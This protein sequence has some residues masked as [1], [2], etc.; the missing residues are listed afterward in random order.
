MGQLSLV[1]A[2][3]ESEAGRCTEV[4]LRN[5]SSHPQDSQSSCNHPRAIADGRVAILEQIQASRTCSATEPQTT[6]HTAP[7]TVA[8]IRLGQALP[9]GCSEASFPMTTLDTRRP[10]N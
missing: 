6:F 8:R 5:R 2:F 9:R 4:T 7:C 10:V 3:K 1:E